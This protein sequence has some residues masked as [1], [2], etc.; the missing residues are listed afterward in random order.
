MR[1]LL[2]T[3]TFIWLDSTPINLSPTVSAICKDPSNDLLV[4]LASVWEIQIKLSAGKL[5]LPRPLQDIIQW[6]QQNNLI[7]ILPVSLHHIFALDN[8]PSHHRD[9]FDR[10]LITQAQTENLI[11]LSRDTEFANYPISVMW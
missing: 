11:I 10:I 5:R 7:H 3:H 4:S 6:Q 1:Y 9:P 8:L 2:D